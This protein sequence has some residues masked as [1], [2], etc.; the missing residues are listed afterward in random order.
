MDTQKD[1]GEIIICEC[2]SIQYY[3]T[4]DKHRESNF[5]NEIMHPYK[6]CLEKYLDT[7]IY[8]ENPK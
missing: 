6:K 2:G 1:V 5:H 3:S 4:I 8:N 7:N